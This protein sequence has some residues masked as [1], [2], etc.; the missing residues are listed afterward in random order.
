MAKTLYPPLLYLKHWSQTAILIVS[1]LINIMSWLWLFWQLRPISSSAIFLHYNVL[2]GVDLVGSWTRAFILP[3]IGLA[4]F[5]L[6]GVVS[7][8]LFNRDRF[9]SYLLNIVSLFCQI[10]IFTASVLIVFLN[11]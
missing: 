10:G 9:A 1:L 7:W 4:I 2:F 5:I 8:Y 3:G 11:I 6:N